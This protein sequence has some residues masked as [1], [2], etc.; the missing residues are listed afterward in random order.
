MRSDENFIAPLN[1][2]EKGGGVKPENDHAG[3]AIGLALDF[4]W[5]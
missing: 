5:A 4:I 1:L 2:D 3:L